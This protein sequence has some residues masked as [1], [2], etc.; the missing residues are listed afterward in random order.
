[1]KGLAECCISYCVGVA[2]KTD[3]CDTPECR[4]E[5]WIMAGFWKA[6]LHLDV[7]FFEISKEVNLLI[8][9]ASNQ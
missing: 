2:D 5:D 3:K 1:M 6:D 4:P 8:R 9:T 7:S